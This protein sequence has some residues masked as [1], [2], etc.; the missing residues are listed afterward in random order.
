MVAISEAQ[1]AKAPLLP[2]V[3]TVANAIRVESFPFNDHKEEFALFLGR[4]HPQKA[5][6]L[7]IEAARE[8]RLP[9]V[10]AGKCAEPI[11]RDYF[12]REIEP[13]LGSDVVVFGPADA[14]ERGTSSLER[15]AC[16]SRSSGTSRSDSS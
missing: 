9:I 12:A 15:G 13:R 1:R 6:H 16:S 4:F 10:L 3:A 5:P 7:A 2:W 11:E 14:A 8:A